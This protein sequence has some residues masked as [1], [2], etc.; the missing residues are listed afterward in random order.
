LGV[1]AGSGDISF[2]AVVFAVWA[3]LLPLP[4]GSRLWQV[5]VQGVASEF[6]RDKAYRRGEECGADISWRD[7][8]KCRR[9]RCGW[10]GAGGGVSVDLSHCRVQLGFGV[11]QQR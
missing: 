4:K 7:P 5:R 8:G 9:A 11:M 10:W 2:R 3:H 1:G 6:S